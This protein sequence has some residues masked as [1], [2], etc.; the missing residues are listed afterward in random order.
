MIRLSSF[1]IFILL[2][3]AGSPAKGQTFQ[4]VVNEMISFLKNNSSQGYSGMKTVYFDFSIIDINTNETTVGYE[5][6][7]GVISGSGYLTYDSVV[8]TKGLTKNVKH[9]LK[10]H[11][12][13]GNMYKWK[14]SRENCGGNSYQSGTF[15]FSTSSSPVLSNSNLA[16]LQLV[17][18]NSNAS[19][20]LSSVSEV[21]KLNSITKNSQTINQYIIHGIISSGG[22]L[23]KYITI[24]FFPGYWTI[25]G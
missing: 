3:W 20:N 7:Q 23:K 8:V 9:F 10:S 1:I 6:L 14:G 19:Y 17:R 25:S 4:E 13:A 16:T 24:S 5:S 2:M 15:Q 12:S 18:Q 11:P 22:G 21:I